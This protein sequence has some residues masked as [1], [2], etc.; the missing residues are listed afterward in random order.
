LNG[1]C[2][3][4]GCSWIHPYLSIN[5][6]Y[7]NRVNVNRDKRWCGRRKKKMNFT[8]NLTKKK[9]DLIHILN[10]KIWKSSW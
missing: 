7:I 1:C 9:H 6:P 3:F 8:K 2:C 10:R 4:S 5:N